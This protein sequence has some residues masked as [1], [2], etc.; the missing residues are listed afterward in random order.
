M[1]QFTGS[2]R[3]PLST[4]LSGWR[5]ARVDGQNCRNRRPY[6]GIINSLAC[7][8]RSTEKEMLR[9]SLAVLVHVLVHADLFGCGQRASHAALRNLVAM[10]CCHGSSCRVCWAVVAMSSRYCR[11]RRRKEY[12]AETD[13]NGQHE[14]RLLL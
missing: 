6:Y 5:M 3:H 8:C 1:F 11:A 10:F 14:R 13:E 7:T 4:S 9:V 12:L 2:V